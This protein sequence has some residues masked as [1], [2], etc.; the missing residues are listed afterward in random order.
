MPNR[1]VTWAIRCTTPRSTTL[2]LL[3]PIREN[4]E[5]LPEKHRPV[6]ATGRTTWAMPCRIFVFITPESAIRRT[7]V[8]SAPPTAGWR[9]ILPT[10]GYTWMA[11]PSP[12]RIV[13][14]WDEAA[15]RT[16]VG[17]GGGL[18][19]RPVRRVGH[20]LDLAASPRGFPG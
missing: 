20:G 10:A 16:I 12:T 5:R 17:C 3:Y 6:T 7:T 2:Y 15:G 11:P 1:R 8:R 4:A 14:T 19:H 18:P 9:S 13:L